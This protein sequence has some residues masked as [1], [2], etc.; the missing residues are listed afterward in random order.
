VYPDW[1]LAPLKFREQLG[2]LFGRRYV[3]IPNEVNPNVKIPN[4]DN[5]KNP[6]RDIPENIIFQIFSGL[7]PFPLT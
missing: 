4:H 7:V 3:K 5:G 1:Y 2:M 6:E